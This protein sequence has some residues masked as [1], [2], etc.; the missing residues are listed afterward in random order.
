MTVYSHRLRTLLH[1]LTEAYPIEVTPQP[2]IRNMF[3]CSAYPSLDDDGIDFSA[4]F[5]DQITLNGDGTST[6]S[7]ELP[8]SVSDSLNGTVSPS[9]I[10]CTYRTQGLYL[11]REQYL[12]DSGNDD[13]VIG[14]NIASAR[15]SGG[16]MV[17]SLTDPVVIVFMKTDTVSIATRL[18][19]NKNFSPNF[20]IHDRL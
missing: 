15:L 4:S 6:I 18:A 1:I 8:G 17:T 16:I 10:F 11:S 5:G 3:G 13:L 12:M 19:R 7:I 2:I 14:S 9:V 20:T